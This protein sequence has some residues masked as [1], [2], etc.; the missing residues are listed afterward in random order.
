[1]RASANKLR[2]VSRR[3]IF[4]FA[5]CFVLLFGIITIGYKTALAQ[6]EPKIVPTYITD[7][8]LG[9]DLP[10]IEGG[11]NASSGEWQIDNN[12]AH[13]ANLSAPLNSKT[14]ATVIYAH[15]KDGLF[16]NLSQLERGDTISIRASNN[17]NYTYKYSND[18]LAVPN[19]GSIFNYNGN[20]KLVLLSCYGTNSELRRLMYFEPL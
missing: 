9:I 20:Y 6:T 1:M 10:I 13:F 5:L 8:K 19:D 2:R 4:V 11:Y 18:T 14:G 3:Q 7:T 12:N 17:Q 15:N 16:A